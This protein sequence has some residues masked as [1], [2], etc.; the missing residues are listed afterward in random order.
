[1]DPSPLY[2]T[3]QHASVVFDLRTRALERAI[4]AGH[5]RAFKIGKKVLL[6]KASIESWIQSNEI[7]PA[8]RVVVKSALQDLMDRAI[9]HAKKRT[10]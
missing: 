8:E 7:T 1:V 4:L 5:I 6:E 10:A 9:A 3:K 2:L